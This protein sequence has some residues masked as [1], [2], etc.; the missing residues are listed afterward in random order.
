MLH[1][2]LVSLTGQLLTPFRA[3]LTH[4]LLWD[5]P[6]TFPPPGLSRDVPLVAWT[7]SLGLALWLPS[8]NAL[9]YQIPIALTFPG[10]GRHGPVLHLRAQPS[11]LR[12]TVSQ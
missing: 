5:P 12:G 7:P 11:W 3:H 10:V 6:G 2:L 8:Q 1:F 4:P 9:V